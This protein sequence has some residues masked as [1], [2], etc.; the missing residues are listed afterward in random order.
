MKKYEYKF[1][2]VSGSPGVKKGIFCVAAKG[3]AF[4]ACKEVILSQAADGW[5]LKQVVVPFNG[6]TGV[7]GARCYQVIFEREA[8]Q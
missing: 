2:K 8:E 6:K 3:A 1:V 4:E 7:Y 5:R